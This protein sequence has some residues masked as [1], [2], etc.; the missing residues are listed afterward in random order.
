ME[1]TDPPELPVIAEHP[2]V[3]RQEATGSS[4]AHYLSSTTGCTVPGPAASTD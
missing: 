2:G 1:Q 3:S 4:T